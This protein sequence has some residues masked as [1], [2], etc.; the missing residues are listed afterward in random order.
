MDKLAD[1]VNVYIQNVQ[2]SKPQFLKLKQNRLSQQAKPKFPEQTNSFGT[3][4]LRM[5]LEP[6]KF[7]QKI[8][9]AFQIREN[10]KTQS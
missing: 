2:P 9:L 10:Q 7:M 5:S 4:Q 3:R 6:R 1:R 8:R